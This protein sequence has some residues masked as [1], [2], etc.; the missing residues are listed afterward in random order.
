MV[1]GAVLLF[2]RRRRSN[3]TWRWGFAIAATVLAAEIALMGVALTVLLSMDTD[4]F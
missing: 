4:R 3:P 2:S 1:S